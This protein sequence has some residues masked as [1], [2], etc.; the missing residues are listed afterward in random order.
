MKRNGTERYALAVCFVSMIGLGLTTVFAAHNTIGALF[1]RFT[2][3]GFDIVQYESDEA[4]ARWQSLKRD[5]A[6][7]GESITARRLAELRAEMARERWDR[8]HD[9]TICALFLVVGGLLFWSHW[10]LKIR[11]SAVHDVG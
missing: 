4:Y 5:N 3:P 1:P 6:D 11:I 8:I 9:L 2:M 7:S 10:R